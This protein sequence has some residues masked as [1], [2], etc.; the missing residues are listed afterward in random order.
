MFKIG[1]KVRYKDRDGTVF[2]VGEISPR[3]L[4]DIHLIET[5][6]PVRHED[7]ELVEEKEEDKALTGGM[8]FVRFLSTGRV[9]IDGKRY[10]LI[11]E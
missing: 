9:M 6:W 8:Y 3:R 7:L 4:E 2:T 5:A 10:K 1:D 11:E